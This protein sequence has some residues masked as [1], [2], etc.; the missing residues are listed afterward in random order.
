[1]IR[2]TRTGPEFAEPARGEY[3]LQAVP[4]TVEALRAIDLKPDEL[5][6]FLA[7]NLGA[8]I[9]LFALADQRTGLVSRP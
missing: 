7:T 4:L 8:G 3:Y 9:D 1:V 6:E 2:G 5:A